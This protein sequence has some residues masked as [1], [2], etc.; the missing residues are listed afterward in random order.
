MGV[1]IQG[2]WTDGELPEETGQTGQFKRIDSAFRDRVSASGSSGFKTELGRHQLYVAHGCPLAH[3]A[4]ICRAFKKLED[5][6][7]IAYAIPG[8][9][10]AAP[11]IAV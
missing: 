11:K 8:R 7:S 2:K 9:K 3:R 10:A 1:L 5:L 4:P 6:V